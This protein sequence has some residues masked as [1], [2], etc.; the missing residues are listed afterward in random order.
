MPKMKHPS[1]R[2]LIDVAPGSVSM[3]E[4][5]GWQLVESV[6][7]ATKRTAKRTTKQTSRRLTDDA[8]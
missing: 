2:R 7:R 6:P 1:G 3:Y 8:K 4:S 5:Q